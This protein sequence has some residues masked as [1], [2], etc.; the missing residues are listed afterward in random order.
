MRILLTNFILILSA[1]AV[2]A[3]GNLPSV[4]L[5]NEDNSSRISFYCKPIFDDSGKA[6]DN[7]MECD[8][9][10]TLFSTQSEHGKFEENWLKSEMKNLFS[11]DGNLLP[12]HMEDFTPMCTREM[13]GGFKTLLGVALEEGEQGP[14]A[15]QL[16]TMN[17]NIAQKHPTEIEDLRLNVKKILGLC[18]KMDRTAM[19]ELA[20]AAYDKETRICRIMNRS[21]TEVYKKINDNLW[22][23]QEGPD[24][25]PCQQIRISTLRLPD[26]ADTLAWEFEFK[27]ISLDKNAE[28]I[29]GTS[30]ALIDEKVDLYTHRS[31]PVFIGCDYM[32]PM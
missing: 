29:L 31:E 26:G 1:G 16:V 12:E 6:S 15:E 24:N 18:L 32:E 20:H 28:S 4:V 14:S 11:E 5:W 7:E 10:S 3:I 22:V 17:A 2:S 21:L 9:T 23:R 13:V 8:S 27:G 30:C 25:S 19:K